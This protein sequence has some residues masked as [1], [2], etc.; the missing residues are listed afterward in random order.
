MWPWEHLAA[1][2]A[3]YSVALRAFESRTPTDAEA[4]M[5]VLGSQ[6]PDLVDKPLSWTF[7]ILPSGTSLAHSVFFAAPVSLVVHALARRL[8]RGSAGTAFAV[9]YLLHLPGDATYGLVYGRR[10]CFGALLWP[11]IPT[12]PARPYGFAAHTSRYVSRHAAF[13][14]TPRG[15]AFSTAELLFLAATAALWAIDGC[16]GLPVT[17]LSKGVRG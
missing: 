8:G 17:R 11:L 13:L 7:R 15:V 1:G 2:Y 6:F 10:A 3:A 12:R 4:A 9:G 14:R 5:I 16:P